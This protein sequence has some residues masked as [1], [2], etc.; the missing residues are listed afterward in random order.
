MQNF[1][2]PA[3]VGRRVIK[4]Y[5]STPTPFSPEEDDLI[6][7]LYLSHKS[8]AQ[9]ARI[10]GRSASVINKRLRK[11]GLYAPEKPSPPKDYSRQK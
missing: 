2:V 3:F 6:K 5:S 11:M 4:R 1:S 8:F 7:T 10:T 9:I